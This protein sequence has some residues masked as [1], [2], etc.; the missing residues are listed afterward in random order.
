MFNS[1]KNIKMKKVAVIILADTDTME[2]MGRV[3]NAFMLI[4]ELAENK[5][6]FKL[7]FEGA[8]A[9]WINELE[10]QD[11]KLHGL[12]KEVKK[13]ITGVCSFCAQAFGGKTSIEKFGIPLI[14]EY[15][16]HPSI[17][18]LFVEGYE[19]ITF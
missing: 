2:A 13:E 7:I 8:G 19:V 4:K 1:K 9:R 11:H 12:Y 17:R 15:N 6:D 5:D 3:S 18:N 16:Q 10:K 14:S